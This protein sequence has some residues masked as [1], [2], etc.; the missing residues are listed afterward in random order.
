[1]RYDLP[2]ANADF[3]PG[4]K[5][6]PPR[7]AARAAEFRDACGPRAQPGLAYGPG[8]RHWFDLFLPEETPRGLAV[9]IHGGY[10]LR[11]GPRDFSHLAAGAVGRGWACAMPAYTLAPGARI[12]AITAENATALPALAAPAA[13]PGAVTS[14]SPRDPSCAAT[15]CP[16]LALAAGP[17]R[18][19]AR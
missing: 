12:A 1:M 11:F 15:G 4:G 18:P 5:D 7:W 16:D 17:A 8:A 9:F 10:W 3:I 13:G 2:F 6:F 14:P 19:L